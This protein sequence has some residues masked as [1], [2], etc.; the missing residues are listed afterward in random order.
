MPV[1]YF[2]SIERAKGSGPDADAWNGTSRQQCYRLSGG[3]PVEEHGWP[4]DRRT[5]SR[6]AEH[7]DLCTTIIH[8]DLR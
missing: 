1:E 2:A 3:P 7:S 6:H 4:R 5:K 8:L